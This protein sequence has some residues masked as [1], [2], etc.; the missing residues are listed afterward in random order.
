MSLTDGA[1]RDTNREFKFYIYFINHFII[2]QLDVLCI[3]LE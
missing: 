1:I 3:A 2:A